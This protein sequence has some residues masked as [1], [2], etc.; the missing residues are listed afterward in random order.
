MK[1][2][3]III[4]AI[5]LTFIPSL[6]PAYTP[7][8]MEE[9]SPYLQLLTEAEPVVSFSTRVP[10]KVAY[11]DGNDQ[12][13]PDAFITFEPQSDTADTRL[14]A[15]NALTGSQGVAE[16]IIEGGTQEVD[17]DIRISVFGDDSVPPLYVRVRVQPE[18]DPSWT[19]G[20]PVE[21]GTYG[22]HIPSSRNPV[23][24]LP[25]FLIPIC[26]VLL[27]KILARKK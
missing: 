25:I 10:V 1:Q 13:I 21:A 17:F 19:V 3:I 23:A 8:N 7:M 6:G 16:T 22:V 12:P 15:R 5:A 14:S 27:L 9:G 4:V 18:T 20:S 26:T 24:T 11:L 2:L